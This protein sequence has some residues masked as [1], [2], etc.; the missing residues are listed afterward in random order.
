[1]HNAD[2]KADAAKDE[3]QGKHN[4]IMQLIE[5]IDSDTRGYK[6]E[7]DRKTTL[8][9]T[10]MNGIHTQI[11]TLVTSLTDQRNSD[12]ASVGNRLAGVDTELTKVSSAVLELSTKFDQLMTVVTNMAAAPKGWEKGK[13]RTKVKIRL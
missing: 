6:A 11:A 4:H 3:A 10:T 12:S 1:M 13:E 9:E 2:I 5:K 8:L 7:N